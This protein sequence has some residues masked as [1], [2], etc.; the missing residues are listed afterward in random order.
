MATSFPTVVLWKGRQHDGAKPLPGP[1]E[2]K[3][4]CSCGFGNFAGRVCCYRC[5][6]LAPIS[7][8]NKAQEEE[9]KYKKSKKQHQ[10]QQQQQQK[11]TRGEASSKEVVQLRKEVA[12]LKKEC[13]GLKG[14]IDVADT[15]EEVP[16]VAERVKNY[17][18]LIQTQ[19]KLGMSSEQAQKE[20]DQLKKDNAAAPSAVK[21]AFSRKKAQAEKDKAVEKRDEAAKELRAAEEIVLKATEKL[22]QVDKELKE[23][24]KA[25]SEEPPELP[26]TILVQKLEGLSGDQAFLQAPGVQDRYNQAKAG[27]DAVRSLFADLEDFSVQRAAQEKVA[28]EQME[29]DK[30]DKEKEQPL[31]RQP[32][33][34]S[35]MDTSDFDGALYAEAWSA[36]AEEPL[37]DEKR[38]KL[39]D[40]LQAAK[41]RRLDSI[42]QLG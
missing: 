1:K 41:K 32:P 13:E 7:V 27:M 31:R 6:G 8:R 33:P 39:D 38:K 12:K 9:A 35:T 22:A 25:G 11:G 42:K 37:S 17:E 36:I 23:A 5:H 21:L 16:T 24:V 19:N 14:P 2:P 18:T 28:A 3:W 30:E 20:L 26:G 4:C 10:Q 40:A 34:P 29:K 15:V